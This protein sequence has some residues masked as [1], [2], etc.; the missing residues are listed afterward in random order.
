MH[1]EFDA[2][3]MDWDCTCFKAFG[4]DLAQDVVTVTQISPRNFSDVRVNIS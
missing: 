2:Q 1:V 3:G 4:D